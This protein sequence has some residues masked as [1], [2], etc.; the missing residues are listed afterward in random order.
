MSI[1]HFTASAVLVVL[2]F[3]LLI[4]G[5]TLLIPLVI[6]TALWYLIN[7]LAQSFHR[8]EIADYKLP[9][10]L[11]RMAAVLM[12]LSLI[13]ALVNFLSASTD[14]V[15]EVAPVYQKNLTSR[16]QD[17]PFVDL[18]AFE[19]RSFSDLLTEWI[20]IP[21]YATTVAS[22]LANIL[23]SGGLILIYLGFLFLE[24]GH[25]KNKIS[26]LVAHPEREAEVLNVITQIRDDIQRYMSIKLFTSSLTGLASYLYLLSVGVDFAGLWGLLIFLLNFIPTVGSIVATLF[27][28]L[29]ALAQS[30]GYSLF[31][32]VLLGIGVLQICIGNILEPRLMGSSFNLS[33]V[34]ILLN[35]ALWNAVWGIPGMFLCVPFLIIVTIVLSH[36]PQTR[37][38]AIM[39]SSDGNLRVPEDEAIANFSFSPKVSAWLV[40]EEKT[41][42]S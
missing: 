38:I 33:P 12:F 24:Q 26:A 8:I 34:V 41:E 22:A 21:S 40:G 4:V 27:P 32:L 20:N 18:A 16:L 25:F 39:L 36:F 31:I 15:L 19:G 6:A 7:T 29:I 5:E 28:A 14:E 1:L 35:L 37:S 23:A 11:C 2:T 3:Y 13:W 17:L 10:L 42:R 9:I 30:E